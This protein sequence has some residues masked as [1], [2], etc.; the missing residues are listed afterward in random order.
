MVRSCAEAARSPTFPSGKGLPGTGRSKAFQAFQGGVA[1]SALERFI[2]VPTEIDQ[3]SS[4]VL[5]RGWAYSIL[6]KRNKRHESR[7][8]RHAGSK[9]QGDRRDHVGPLCR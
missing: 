2:T 3:I 4:F 9:P 1:G 8:R 5:M 6:L 7:Q